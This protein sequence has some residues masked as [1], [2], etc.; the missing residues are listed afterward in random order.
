MTE[1][2]VLAQRTGRRVLSIQEAGDGAALISVTAG[3]EPDQSIVLKAVTDAG[4]EPVAYDPPRD[5][6]KKVED[7][8]VLRS[9][10]V[11]PDGMDSF[12]VYAKA[13]KLEVQAKAE[14][15]PEGPIDVYVADQ[16][17]RT[18]GPGGTATIGVDVR[19]MLERPVVQAGLGAVGVAIATGIV[20]RWLKWW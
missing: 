8:W 12:R 18:I 3:G 2:K 10:T 6:F 1:S 9:A 4:A 15:L 13:F 20:G 16:K 14:V 11:F 7:G 17:V 5:E 19:P